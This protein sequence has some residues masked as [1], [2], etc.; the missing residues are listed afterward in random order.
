MTTRAGPLLA[1]PLPQDLADQK[2]LHQQTMATEDFCAAVLAAH[3]ALDAE[4]AATGGG[5]ILALS[6][7]PWLM[8]QPHRIRAFGAMLDAILAKGG[9][10][11]ATGAEIAQAWQAQRA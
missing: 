10:W 4:A 2:M 5:R 9:V 6:V 7:T 1:M 3:A 8:G 11:N